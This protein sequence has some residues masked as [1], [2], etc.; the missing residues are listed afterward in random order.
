[1]TDSAE[2]KCILVVDDQESFLDLVASRLELMDGHRLYKAADGEAAVR[3]ARL[4]APDLILLDW[5][6]PGMSGL[7]ALK[8]LK[9]G[10]ATRDIPVYMLTTQNLMGNVE[11]ALTLGAEGYITKPIV[12]NKL[13][14]RVKRIFEE[15]AEKEK[16]G[17]E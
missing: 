16:P 1:M 11:D 3:L 10:A 17:D 5:L 15:L 12:M 14:A 6:M 9:E 2:P 4:Q 13:S 7:E 8:L